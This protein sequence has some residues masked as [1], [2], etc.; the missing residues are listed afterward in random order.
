MKRLVKIGNISVPI[1]QLAA[2]RYSVI[3]RERG[4]RIEKRR[5]SLEKARAV[6]EEAAFRIAR[7]QEAAVSGFR[8]VRVPEILEEFLAFKA[9][10]KISPKYLR[11]LKGD[12]KPFARAFPSWIDQIDALAISKYLGA[13]GIGDRRRNNIRDEIVTLSLFAKKHT[14][15]RADLITEAEKVPR[16]RLERSAP[17]IYS[18]E[19]LQIII[20][21]VS[22]EWL[23]WIL[24]GAFAG[25]RPEEIGLPHFDRQRR[26]WIKLNYRDHF[27]WEDRQILIPAIISKTKRHRYVTIHDTL[28]AWIA[29]RR[30]ESGNVCTLDIPKTRSQIFQKALPFRWINDGLRHSFA[31]YWQSI[32]SDMNRLKEE[33]GNSEAINR[34]YYF[35]PQPK[36]IAL[37]W[38]AI[39]PE[40]S[41]NIIQ[42][43]KTA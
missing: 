9:S 27:F 3:Y 36:S 33:M 4:K 23:D 12:L 18:P 19:Q 2:G 1:Y 43:E 14:F 16:I 8:R 32:H 28:F 6:A 10:L 42:L 21:S 30:V 15:L 25:V 26:E 7:G 37:R 24:L 22:G 39:L 31:S 17:E 35:N 5:K 34:R 41:E 38:F 40:N 20:D 11:S 13:L 29:R